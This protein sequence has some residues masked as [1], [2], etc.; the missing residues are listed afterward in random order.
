[1]E[2]L[3]AQFLLVI[4]HRSHRLFWLM[5]SNTEQFEDIRDEA[6]KTAHTDAMECRHRE[7]LIARVQSLWDASRESLEAI[8]PGSVPREEA[9]RAASALRMAEQ[10]ILATASAAMPSVA[11][12][13]TVE[14]LDRLMASLVESRLL[15]VR[16]MARMMSQRDPDGRSADEIA[17]I[18]VRRLRFEA[19]RP[20]ITA[21]D[22]LELP[23]PFE[24]EPA[25]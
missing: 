20:V 18:L 5:P 22:A 11:K 3:K 24:S 15:I 8:V 4:R 1:M 19:G 16:P 13:Y 6:W 25:A 9:R 21:R 17:H 12:G 14:G 2:A 7:S 23:C 10:A